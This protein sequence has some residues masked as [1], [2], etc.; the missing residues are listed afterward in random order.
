MKKN[1]DKKA[2][3]YLKKVDPILALAIDNSLE[4]LE[5]SDKVYE[6]LLSSI[7][8][9]QISVAAARSVEHKFLNFFGGSFPEYKKLINTSDDDLRS[10]GL[11]YQKAS[12]LKNIAVYFQENNLQ[13]HDFANMQDTEI[14]KKLTEIKGVGKWTVEMLLMFTLAR[15]DIFSIDDLGLVRGCEKLYDLK[16][17]KTLN[18]RI[19]KIS[20]KWSPYRSLASRYLWKFKDTK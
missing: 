5:I 12:Y 3:A 17:T 18:K 11:S 15:P 14:L 8:G 10:C 6:S 4:V 9:Q 2:H 13:D 1:I 7:I 19:L 16:K 20:E